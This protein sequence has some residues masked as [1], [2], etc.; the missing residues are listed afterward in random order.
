MEEIV[1]FEQAQEK[2]TQNK[3]FVNASQSTMTGKSKI[4]FAGK[5]NVLFVEDGVRIHDSTVS[6]RGDDS[7]VYLSKNKHR[8]LL[9]ISIYHCSTVYIGA[10]CYINGQLT[11][12][13]SERQNIVIGNEGLFSFGIFVRTADPHL[14]YDCKTKRRINPSKS[15]F[16]G[17]HV[18]IGQNALILKG[19]QIG[20]GS[21]IG[22]NAVLSGKKIASNVV[23]CG[24][25]ARV[26]RRGVFFLP[27]CV[28]AWTEEKTTE[29][30]VRDSDDY[31][32]PA[33]SQG[34]GVEQIDQALKS[35]PSGDRRLA[36]VQALFCENPDRT[37][38]VVTE[39]V[40]KRPWQF[41]KSKT[42]PSGTSPGTLR[43]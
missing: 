43:T 42:C 21:V 12:I 15:V 26:V 3:V 37:R 17:D 36:L 23:A 40:K 2:L 18:W 16:I 9:H 13:A 30:E 39:E 19:A 1:S 4:V 5:N 38:F 6:F 28:H 35:A 31:I 11:L 29:Y 32:Y 34:M 25:P 24:N 7:V 22:A 8:Y 10:D 20:S 27:E 41:W 33:Q 14:L